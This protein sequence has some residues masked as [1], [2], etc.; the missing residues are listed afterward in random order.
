[1]QTVIPYLC[2]HDGRGALDFYARAFGAEETFRV[3]MDDG[4]LG[5]ASFTIG[6]AEFYL[7]DEFP[8][9]DVKSPSL[10]GGTSFAIYLNT[11]D[12][13][14]VFTAAVEAGATP[15]REPEDQEHGSRMAVVLDP[16]GHRWMI[17]GPLTT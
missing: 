11:E 5:H 4:R 17:A 14:A 15:L 6:D 16:F 3:E 9:M 2:A 7:S 1:M 10:L 12:A 13:D 8:E